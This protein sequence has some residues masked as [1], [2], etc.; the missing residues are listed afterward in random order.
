MTGEVCALLAATLCCE[1][2]AGPGKL[3]GELPS[4]HPRCSC[5]CRVGPRRR[6]RAEVDAGLTLVPAGQGEFLQSVQP[7]F[8]V[9]PAP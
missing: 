6:R 2:R 1:C 7:P 8:M 4:A 9:A 5:A 3:T